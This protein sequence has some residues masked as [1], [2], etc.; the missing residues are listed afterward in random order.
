MQ[1]RSPSRIGC[2]S[3]ISRPATQLASVERAANP[4]T[5]PSTAEEASRPPA[6]ARTCGVTSS[7]QPSTTRRCQ[8]GMCALLRRRRAE[9][10]VERE[11]PAAREPVGEAVPEADLGLADPPAEADLLAAP[12]SREVEQALRR[13]LHDRAELGDPADTAAH[14]AGELLQPLAE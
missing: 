5:S 12:Q 2:A 10:S 1:T 9:S 13:V 4:I 8:S 11:R 3:A 14:L 7:T 6:T